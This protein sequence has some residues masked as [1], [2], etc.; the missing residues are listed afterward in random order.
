M[1]TME[2]QD[3]NQTEIQTKTGNFKDV[4]FYLHSFK[5]VVR[6]IHKNSYIMHLI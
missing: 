4:N 3:R 2:Q 1:K 6:K 5:N